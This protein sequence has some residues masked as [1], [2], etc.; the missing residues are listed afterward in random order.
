MGFFSAAGRAAGRLAA[1]VQG[2]IQ[3]AELENFENQLGRQIAVGNAQTDP[4]LNFFIKDNPNNDLAQGVRK[5]DREERAKRAPKTQSTSQV[6][7][8]ALFDA[9]N[10]IGL[11]TNIKQKM[12]PSKYEKRMA[13]SA[14]DDLGIDISPN[15]KSKRSS[16]LDRV[17][18]GDKDK[19]SFLAEEKLRVANEPAG[20]GYSREQLVDMV[21][22]PGFPQGGYNNN[23]LKQDPRLHAT[24]NMK[25]EGYIIR[26]LVDRHKL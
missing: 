22:Q 15:N 9:A 3:K 23:A 19:R 2:G 20:V 17:K 25:Y 26:P 7:D 18:F 12:F 6:I 21:N 10:D 24:R 11:S 13:S 14:L 8:A 5:Y 16:D 4:A 1:D